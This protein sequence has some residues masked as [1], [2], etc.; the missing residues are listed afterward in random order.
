MNGLNYFCRTKKWTPQ[1]DVNLRYPKSL[2][3]KVE[4][5]VILVFFFFYMWY[6]KNLS[7]FS[8]REPIQTKPN[9][10]DWNLE[11]VELGG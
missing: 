7:I 10:M 4:F 1:V 11:R 6:A 5:Y 2:V 9:I 8:L 3:P